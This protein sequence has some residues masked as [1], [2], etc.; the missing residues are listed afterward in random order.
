MARDNKG[1]SSEVERE[2][3]TIRKN[4]VTPGIEP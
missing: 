2:K 3:L 1:K 4:F